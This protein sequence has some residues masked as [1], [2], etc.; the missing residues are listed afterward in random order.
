MRGLTTNVLVWVSQGERPEMRIGVKEFFGEVVPG[1][2]I[3]KQGIELGKG[4]S[5]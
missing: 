3:R 4:K 2:I 5:Q 1:N